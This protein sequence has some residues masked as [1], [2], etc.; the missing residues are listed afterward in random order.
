MAYYRGRSRRF[1]S[2][3]SPRRASR[4]QFWVRTVQ[5][6]VTHD[7]TSGMGVINLLSPADID[8]GA[9]VGSTVIRTRIDWQANAGVISSLYGDVYFGVS[10]QDVD[11]SYVITPAVDYNN[12]DWM[13]W[14]RKNISQLFRS[15]AVAPGTETVFAME[16]DVK[17]KRKITLP[18]TSLYFQWQYEAFASTPASTAVISASVLLR[19]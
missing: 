4:Q 5:K 12:F 10:L 18:G 11:A 9:L 3:Y 13:H 19:K 17:S 15:S 16:I 1:S 7:A 6:G 8:P 14:S 2:R